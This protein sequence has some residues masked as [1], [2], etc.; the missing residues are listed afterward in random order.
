M[1]TLTIEETFDDEHQKYVRVLAVDDEVF[2][3]GMDKASLDQ[4]KAM[5][6]NHPDLIGTVS[7]DIINHFLACFSE[8]IGRDITLA[9]LNEAIRLGYIEK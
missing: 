9:E 5:V 8:F 6:R 1:A 7:C 2:D 3:W 4:V